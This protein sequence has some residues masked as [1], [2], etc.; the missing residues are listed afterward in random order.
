V[1]NP[2]ENEE[3]RAV[4]GDILRPGGL[5]VTK[6]ALELCAF[7]A[8]SRLIDLGCGPGGTLKFLREQ[9]FEAVGVDKS[10]AFLAEAKVHGPVCEADFHDLPFENDYADGLLC[11]CA[12][13]LARDKARVLGECFRVLKAGGHLIVS[14]IF[15]IM[16]AGAI[17]PPPAA[18][19]G[20]CLH[21]AVDLETMRKLLLDSGFETEH[22]VDHSRALKELAAGLV[23]HFGSAAA[24]KELF[25]GCVAGGGRDFGY[26]LFI[27]RRRKDQ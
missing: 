14:D 13:S 7:P 19:P 12:L 20:G 10:P 2:Y 17:S 9:G 4:C 1:P 5:A 8:G 22:M 25:G 15:R 11:E 21:G 18:S 23:W 26:A 3:L 24:L 16:K 6:Q 27:A